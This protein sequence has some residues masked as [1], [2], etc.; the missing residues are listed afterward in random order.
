M[1]KV[2]FKR[3][4]AGLYKSSNGYTISKDGDWA[5][6]WSA[7]RSKPAPAG[8]RWKEKTFQQYGQAKEWVVSRSANL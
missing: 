1:E 6:L 4:Y 8:Y 2:T 7:Y 5:G 3:I